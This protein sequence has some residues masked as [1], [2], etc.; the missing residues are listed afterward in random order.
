MRSEGSGARLRKVA[1]HRL[2]TAEGELRMAVVEIDNGV[3][4]AYRHLDGEEPFT[5]WA[6]GEIV[7][8]R[9]SHGKL[10]AFHGGR[11]LE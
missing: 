11:L 10:R 2:V 9:D 3:V 5:E 6:G 7:L 4:T 8:D 1:A